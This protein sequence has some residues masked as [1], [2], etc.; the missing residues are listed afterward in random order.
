MVKSAN[1]ETVGRP[2]LTMSLGQ[3]AVHEGRM[4]AGFCFLFN[5]LMLTDIQ[6]MCTGLKCPLKTINQNDGV[7]H[8]CAVLSNA[9][10]C[11]TCL[12]MEFMFCIVC[13]CVLLCV[14]KVSLR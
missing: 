1:R 8:A 14:F 7:S 12:K 13:S 4:S 9:I 5:W 11:Y 10:K 2:F 6:P 3:A